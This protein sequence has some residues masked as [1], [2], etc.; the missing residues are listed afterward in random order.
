M[1]TPIY[2][3]VDPSIAGDSGAGTIGSP[4]GD[5]QYALNQV[6][7]SPGRDATHGDQF[8]VKAGTDEILAAILSFATYGVP[9][10]AAPCIIRGYASAAN[11][12]DFEAGTGIGGIDGNNGNFSISSTNYVYY[13]HMRLHNTG[14]VNLL[15][16]AVPMRV[17]FCEL[18]TAANG[19][20]TNISDKV[21]G[22][23]LHDISG[24]TWRG[25]T[26]LGNFVDNTQTGKMTGDLYDTGIA[27]SACMRNI[28]VVDSA[29][30]THAISIGDD[31]CRA[32]GN[33]IFATGAATG[34]GISFD[35]NRENLELQNNLIEGFIGAGGKGIDGVSRSEGYLVFTNNGVRNCSTP[36]A[37][38]ADAIYESDNETLGASPF[39]KSGAITFAN[40][41]TY[42]APVDTGNVHGGGFPVGS[43]VDKGAVQHADPAGGGPPL[44]Q[45]RRNTMIG[46]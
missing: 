23:H 26:F 22:C 20:A 21:I 8:N 40:R 4:Y 39:A 28:F 15:A 30:S 11:D 25:V 34:T 41:F 46:R 16:V 31:N 12:G 27:G 32:S 36:Y 17:L 33:S 29:F 37:N 45:T 19:S 44:I 7:T 18:D 42:F 14:T 38:A 3:Y 35:V 6:G 43:R 9:T 24:N 10:M 13:V 1:G 2:Y 5:L